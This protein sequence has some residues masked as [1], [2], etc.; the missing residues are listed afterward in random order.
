MFRYVKTLR[1]SLFYLV[2]AL[3]P[4]LQT[5]SGMIGRGWLLLIGVALLGAGIFITNPITDATPRIANT[6]HTI[7]G[8]LVILTF[9]IVATLVAGSLAR[10]QAWA[11]GQPRLVWETFLVWFGMGAFFGSIIISR[12]INPAAGRVGPQVY[13][14]WPNR[15]MVVTYQIWLIRAALLTVLLPKSKVAHLRA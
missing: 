12:A 10:N 1:L 7:C 3:W 4:M 15:F 2:V 13:L 9:P 14:G 5:T 8:A 6:L 11:S